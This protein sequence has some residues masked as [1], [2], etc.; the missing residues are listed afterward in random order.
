MPPLSFREGRLNFLIIT[1]KNNVFRNVDVESNQH[2]VDIF[3][4]KLQK[5]QNDL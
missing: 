4:T 1:T 2:F 5:N 3:S